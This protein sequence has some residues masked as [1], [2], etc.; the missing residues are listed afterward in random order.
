MPFLHTSAYFPQKSSA[1]ESAPLAPTSTTVESFSFPFGVDRFFPDC[2]LRLFDFPSVARIK[3]LA[4]R[5]RCST[6]SLACSE[7]AISSQVKG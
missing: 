5:G 7:D 2:C 1:A 6:A 3:I 4:G